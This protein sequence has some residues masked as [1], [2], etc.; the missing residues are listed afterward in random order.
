MKQNVAHGG[1]ARDQFIEDLG[2]TMV[3]WGLTR[4]T[5][6]MY[7]YLLLRSGPASLD[8]M[9]DELDIAKSGA[10]VAARQLVAIGLARAT[11]SK[12][13]RRVLYEALLD[14]DN[15]MAAR[16]AQ[17]RI[18]ADRLRQGAHAAGSGVARR[19]LDELAG[20]VEDLSAELPALV[21]RVR[22]RRRK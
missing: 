1:T 13:S 2:H 7:A 17:T 18:F 15:I 22:E 11:G 3:G 12:G 21:R 6:R 8:E 20:I 4:T 14:A 9:A 5:G 16:N 10:S 19:R